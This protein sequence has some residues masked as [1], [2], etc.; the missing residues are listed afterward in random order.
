MYKSLF[1]S[2]THLGSAYNNSENLFDFLENIEAEQLF[3][4]GDIVN[5]SASK[6][7]PD[8][9]RFMRLIQ[10]KKWKIIYIAGNN[11]DD[12]LQ[13]STDSLLFTKEFF[14]KENY[15]YKNGQV[16]IYLEHGHRFHAEGKI[17][18]LL[19]QGL[20]YLKRFL[21]QMRKR[22]KMRSTQSSTG[23]SKIQKENFYH[24]YIKPFAQKVLRYSFKS[25]MSVRTREKGCSI[26]VCGHFHIPEDTMVKGI[27]YLNCGDWVKSSSYIV[28]NEGGEF[29]L[30]EE[31]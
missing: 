10:S 6:E 29:V 17:N 14:P 15:I 28:E 1:I 20:V 2:D 3:L 12:R 24:R 13:S 8:V 27:R 5:G 22:K 19:H 31:K 7:H 11:E 25:Y 9:V 4:L 18:R 16:S 26:V 30:I 21:S 23:S